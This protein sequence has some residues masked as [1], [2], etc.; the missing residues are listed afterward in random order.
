MIDLTGNIHSFQSLGA[1]DG[2]GIRFAVFMQGCALRCNYCHNPDTW[3]Y[4]KGKD[5]TVKEVVRNASRYKEYFAREGGVSVS[6]GEPLLQPE[7]LAGL[8]GELRKEKIHTVLDTCG[9]YTVPGTKKPKEPERERVKRV[10]ENTDL[11]IC[12]IKYKTQWEYEKYCKGSLESVIDFLEMSCNMKIP[13]WVRH[14]AIPGITA[15]REY[16]R[17]IYDLAK[18]FNNL[19]KFEILP[20]SDICKTKYE[21]MGMTF[22]LGDVEKLS[23]REIE[24][25]YP[26]EYKNHNENIIKKRKG[27]THEKNI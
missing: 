25:L 23:E 21:N 7:F 24:K 14:V 12:D 2:P 6:G 20:F 13:L 15:S 4:K 9:I 18:G 8:F 11:I 3:N 22:S 10:L 1:R 16:I 19:E 26:G 27:I 17:G 5:Y